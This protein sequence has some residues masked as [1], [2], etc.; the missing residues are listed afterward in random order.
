MVIL[1]N[2][3]FSDIFA[4]VKINTGMILEQWPTDQVGLEPMS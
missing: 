2:K 1:G 3:N 4:I